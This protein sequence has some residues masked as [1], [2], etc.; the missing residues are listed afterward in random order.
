M[1]N[2]RPLHNAASYGHVD[3]T[4]LLIDAGCDLNAQDAYL[5]TPLH[6]ACL[7]R[8]YAICRLLVRSGANVSLKN[9]DGRSPL[10]LARHLN[11]A[12]L[13]DILRGDAAFLDACK[14][15]DLRRVRKLIDACNVNSHDAQNNRRHSTPLHLAAG[16]NHLKVAELLLEYGA[17]AVIEDRGGL[18]PLHNAASYGVSLKKV[19]LSISNLFVNHK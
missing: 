4:R 19:L 1:A 15:G 3:I 6:E 5:F 18:V 7:K 10:E 11:D 12:E 2:L 13:V 14:Q 16:Y 17:D 9:R 8:K